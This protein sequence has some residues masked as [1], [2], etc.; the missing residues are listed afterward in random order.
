MAV[1]L[2]ICA[3][4]LYRFYVWYSVLTIKGI[5]IVTRLL[6]TVHKLC[7]EVYVDLDLT[8]AAFN[9]AV[10]LWRFPS[11]IESYDPNCAIVSSI[12]W[13]RF[14][15]NHNLADRQAHKPRWQ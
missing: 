1:D 9:R 15:A 8:P 2:Q 5:N 3:L 14:I 11:V 6:S 7:A 4:M 13:I 12:F 10:P